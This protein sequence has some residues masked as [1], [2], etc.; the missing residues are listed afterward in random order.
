MPYVRDKAPKCANDCKGSVK[1]GCR[2]SVADVSA[3]DR[4]VLRVAGSKSRSAASGASNVKL[5]RAMP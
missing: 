5:K 4:E 1:P 3:L 2:R